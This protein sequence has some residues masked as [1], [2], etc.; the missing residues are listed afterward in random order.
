MEKV[1]STELVLAYC[2]TFLHCC[3]SCRLWVA[4]LLFSISLSKK[5][6]SWLFGFFLDFDILYPSSKLELKQ[7]HWPRAVG[8]LVHFDARSSPW[9]GFYSAP[10][11]LWCG[12]VCCNTVPSVFC[13]GGH[14]GRWF[15]SRWTSGSRVSQQ[16]V[17]L[18]QDH[19][20]YSLYPSVVSLLELIAD[21]LL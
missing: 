7:T 9:S 10:H 14:T 16:H 12:N 18:R 21:M 6:V 3:L 2:D 4:N 13:H 8:W 11:V 1:A 17:N 20:R 5:N 19:Y 15:V